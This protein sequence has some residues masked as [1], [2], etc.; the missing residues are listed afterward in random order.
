MVR[1]SLSVGGCSPSDPGAPASFGRVR[2]VDRRLDLDTAPP[3]VSIGR[4]GA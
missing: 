2:V 4:E 3:D 1:R